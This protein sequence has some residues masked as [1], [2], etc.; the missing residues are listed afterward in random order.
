M[1]ANRKTLSVFLA[2]TTFV[3]SVSACGPSTTGIQR[4]LEQTQAA[5]LTSTPLPAGILV[6]PTPIPLSEIDL[7]SLLIRSGDLPSGVTAG[8]ITDWAGGKFSEAP[9]P[10][11]VGFQLFESKGAPYGSVTVLVY[12]ALADAETTYGILHDG[13]EGG[14]WD[15]V[16]VGDKAIVWTL[17]MDVLG[18]TVESGEVGFIRCG[19]VVDILM[20]TTDEAVITAYAKRLDAR[21]RE[22][23]CR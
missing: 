17:L 8:Q 23:V 10:A 7:E 2:V 22:A 19:A 14:G 9:T 6:T 4:A 18:N 3:L 1:S 12:D 5:I 13:L 11:Q 21:L 20:G 16:G 15:V